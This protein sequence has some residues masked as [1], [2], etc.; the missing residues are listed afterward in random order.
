MKSAIVTGGA[1]GIGAAICEGLAGSGYRVG[2]LDYDGAAAEKIAAGLAHA[3]AVQA[4]ITDEASVAEALRR[5]GDVPDVLVNNAGIAAKGGLFQDVATF[6]RLIDVNLVGAYV[7]SRAI[8]PEMIAR[9][10]GAIINITSIAATSPNPAGGAYGPSK[11][12]LSN[13]TKAMAIELAPHG[14]RVNAVAPGMIAS[15][16]GASPAADPVVRAERVAMI[17]A[18]ELGTAK[19]IVDVVLFLS[20]DAARYVQGQEIVVDGGLT[21]S[22]L[23]KVGKTSKDDFATRKR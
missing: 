22:T 10:S 6:R 9:G 14:I 21:L 19:D 5:F 12:A 4:D 8:Y 2:V 16:L 1:G 13:L 11:A 18:G 17:P 7:V 20:S 23:A 3:V 15:G